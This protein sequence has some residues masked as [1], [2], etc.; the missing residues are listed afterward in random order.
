[1]DELRG[2]SCRLDEIDG[3]VFKFLPD[4]LEE[5]SSDVYVVR[6]GASMTI[7]AVFVLSQSNLMLDTVD[8]NELHNDFS[9]VDPAEIHYDYYPAIE[10]DLL[11]VHKD[12]QHTH[13]GRTIIET[14]NR[15][16]K[17]F[18]FADCLFIVVDA[19]FNEDYT[20]V[21]FYESCGFRMTGQ[22]TTVDT[23]RLFKP[24]E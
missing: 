23:W 1:M 12:C 19:Y 2:F 21:P 9:D 16:Y 17:D 8:M 11:A 18:G 20:A 10:L 6:Q 15:Y 3:I 22:I 4:K 14:I 13:V 24:I 5:G 7:C